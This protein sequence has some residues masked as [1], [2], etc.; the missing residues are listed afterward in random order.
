MEREGDA[1]AS[2]RRQPHVMSWALPVLQGKLSEQPEIQWAFCS[3]LD[4]RLKIYCSRDLNMNQL[5]IV[6]D[7][8]RF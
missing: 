3:P 6:M 2:Q 7:Q 4:A 1:A 5:V 8:F